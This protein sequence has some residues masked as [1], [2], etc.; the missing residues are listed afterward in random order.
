[1]K[2]SD[3]QKARNVG[4][5]LRNS[6]RHIYFPYFKHKS[7]IL[8]SLSG[9]KDIRRQRTADVMLRQL[10]SDDLYRRLL[11]LLPQHQLP[12]LTFVR[13]IGRAFFID[14]ENTAM[15]RMNA[16]TGNIILCV[17]LIGR[18]YFYGQL[19]VLVYPESVRYLMKLD[20]FL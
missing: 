12:R 2:E 8:Y 3:P 15:S 20:T 19:R 14:V 16:H 6:L 17:A 5:L 18:D 11:V 7:Q 1:M 4:L 9:E 13:M 10:P